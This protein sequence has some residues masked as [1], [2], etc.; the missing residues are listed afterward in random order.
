[1]HRSMCRRSPGGA[2]LP[3]LELVQEG[4]AWWPEEA[5]GALY[6]RCWEE[7][8]PRGSRHCLA[9]AKSRQVLRRRAPAAKSRSHL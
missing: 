9:Y 3:R 2:A 5:P 7:G 4:R 8:R 6:R 1:M